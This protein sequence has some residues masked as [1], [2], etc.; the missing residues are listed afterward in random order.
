MALATLRKSPLWPTL[1]SALVIP[2]AGQI[3][4]KE[5]SKGLLLMGAFFGAIVWFS[6]SVT[7][8][9]LTVLPGKPEDWIKDQAA[10]YGAVMSLINQQAS[11]FMTFQLLLFL[12]WL[13]GVI[14]A[15]V[16]AKAKAKRSVEPTDSKN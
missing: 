3:Y 1:L 10:F 14:D 7:A 16:I 6:Q 8:H 2:G 9:L 15:Y 5:V 11:M 4:N 12:L 13:Y